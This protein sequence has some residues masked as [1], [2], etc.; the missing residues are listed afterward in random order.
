MFTRVPEEP[1][2]IEIEKGDCYLERWKWEKER[3]VKEKRKIKEK[4]IFFFYW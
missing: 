4:F 3:R 2:S 1:A